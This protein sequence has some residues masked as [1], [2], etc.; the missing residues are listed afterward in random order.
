VSSLPFPANVLRLVWP[1]DRIAAVIQTVVSKGGKIYG[2][3]RFR[4]P[5][6][7]LTR[8]SSGERLA[9]EWDCGGILIV[10]VS[11]VYTMYML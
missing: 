7:L 11:T 8:T 5:C 1:I 3:L 9:E 2:A 4:V 6:G 10:C